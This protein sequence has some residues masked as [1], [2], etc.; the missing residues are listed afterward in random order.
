MK[1]FVLV[2]RESNYIAKDLLYPIKNLNVVFSLTD[3]KD[4][5]FSFKIKNILKTI[6]IV[7]VFI[8]KTINENSIF[9]RELYYVLNSNRI[10]K[11]IVPIVINAAPI[12]EQLSRFQSILYD[13][14]TMDC[15]TKARQKIEEL[16]PVFEEKKNMQ[17]EN[18]YRKIQKYSSLL[19]LI[20]FPAIMLITTGIIIV[21]I[22]SRNIKNYESYM[23]IYTYI[24]FITIFMVTLSFLYFLRKNLREDKTKEKNSYSQKIDSALVYEKYKTLK[25][26]NSE[27]NKKI[28]TEKKEIDVLG[29]AKLNLENINDYYSWSQKQ[30]KASFIL[31]VIMSILGFALVIAGIILPIVLKLSIEIAFIPAIGGVITELIAGTALVVYRSS[32]SQLNHYHNALHEDERFLSSVNLLNQFSTVESQDE[33]LKEIIR[34]EIQMNVIEAENRKEVEKPKK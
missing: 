1:A 23:M 7:F 25:N 30:A 15:E 4:I 22:V 21:F 13:S 24:I 33:M 34:S 26:S 19:S 9:Q 31:A 32:L 3:E 29:L 28:S 17:E 2:T 16:L 12:P 8:D 20:F 11:F 10:K 5:E 14:K 18:R 27:S 6:D